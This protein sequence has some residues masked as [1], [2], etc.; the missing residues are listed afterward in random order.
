[1]SDGHVLTMVKIET[2]F[3]TTQIMEYWI[4]TQSPWVCTFLR[5]WSHFP[6]EIVGRA[7]NL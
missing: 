2:I 6:D 3:A 1:M 5:L 4:I 7:L